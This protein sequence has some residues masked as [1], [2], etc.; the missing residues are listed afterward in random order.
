MYQLPPGLERIGPTPSA[1]TPVLH[2]PWYRRRRVAV[3]LCTF[4]LL[5]L[6]GLSWSY[7][8]PEIYRSSASILTTAPSEIDRLWREDGAQENSVSSEPDSAHIAVQNQILKDYSLLKEVRN[9]MNQSSPGS[10]I[11]D[12]KTSE[13][14][15]MLSVNPEPGSQL[16]ELSAEGTD[17]LVLPELVNAWIETYKEFRAKHVNDATNATINALA[18]QAATLEA[19]VGEK[20]QRLAI[21]RQQS[22]I[23]T[24]EA[25]ENQV[26]ARLKGLNES[27]NEA[28][29][30][31]V[32]TKARLDAIK[33]AIAD[34][35]PVFLENSSGNER[36]TAVLEE[37]AQVLREKLQ[38]LEQQYTPEYIQLVPELKAVPEQLKAIEAKMARMGQSDQEVVLSE[39][40]QAYSAAKQKAAAI[41][42]QMDEHKATA[43]Q[44]TAQ[45]SQH[46]VLKNEL[47]ILA[48]RLQ[49]TNDK[50]LQA[51]VKLHHKY[52]QIDV[53]RSAFLPDQPVSPNYLRDAASILGGAF[54]LALIT[55]LLIEFLSPEP[56]HL[57]PGITL[58]GIHM[59]PD[60]DT[61]QLPSMP[62]VQQLG[63]Q[64]AVAKL[65]TPI[66]REL[67]QEEIAKL[68]R[69]SPTKGKQLLSMLLGGISITE[70]STLTEDSF[71][72]TRNTVTL[73][74]AYPRILNV[75]T[76]LKNALVESNNKPAWQDTE[77]SIDDLGAFLICIAADADIE[78]HEQLNEGALRHTYLCHLV[79]QGTRLSELE[80]VT[81]Y[82]APGVLNFYRQISPAGPGRPLAELDLDFPIFQK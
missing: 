50:L 47:G 73:D 6:I 9:R 38:S 63:Q 53:V 76:S 48:E 29:D 36:R 43:Q 12:F 62:Q 40:Q 19:Q 60:T 23:L 35:K 1:Q 42:Q 66:P 32:K 21:F 5:S 33:A 16:I 4:L 46:E 80:S 27:L 57:Q 26:L 61:G 14:V 75:S 72:L 10:T 68:W 56:K 59:Y 15:N 39:A 34:G 77:F 74:G 67:T 28:E 31:Q 65:E 25:A 71:D 52:P 22:D 7:S 81:G 37:A 3:F 55:V 82:L 51:K 17:P 11:K 8:R 20:R 58:S 30:D 45:F 41:R 70:A 54:L 18:D 2:L 78:D 49:A 79:R 44:F 64:N 13:I 69:H 24:D